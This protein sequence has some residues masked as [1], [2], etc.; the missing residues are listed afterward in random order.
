MAPWTALSSQS[1][2][3][4]LF[5]VRRRASISLSD[6]RFPA[7]K[8]G[9]ITAVETTASKSCARR[10][11]RPTRSL[12]D[13][14]EKPQESSLADLRHQLEQAFKPSC[15]S[16]TVG[17][18]L[19]QHSRHRWG[20]RYQALL[21][22]IRHRALNQRVPFQRDMTLLHRCVH[23]LHAPSVSKAPSHSRVNTYPSSGPNSVPWPQCPRV[24]C[25]HPR[26]K[27]E[28]SLLFPVHDPDRDHDSGDVTTLVS[29]LYRSSLGCGLR[30]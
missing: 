29:S 6:I 14:V 15:P 27:T 4:T 8:S 13:I 25:G 24:A 2:W 30:P 21:V 1:S 26:D 7:A 19:A 23:P 10:Y 9:I 18:I 17:G 11:R 28:I 22:E 12:G 3:P 16:E 20:S 5:P